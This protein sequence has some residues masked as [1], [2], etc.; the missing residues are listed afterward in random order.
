M[1]EANHP[2]HDPGQ[3][4][5]APWHE[6]DAVAESIQQSNSLNQ[7]QSH[8][9]AWQA[10]E[11]VDFPNAISV[12]AID[13]QALY[14]DDETGDH[15]IPPATSFIPDLPLTQPAMAA[16]SSTESSIGS[17][18]G[19][20]VPPTTA[21]L[22][23]LIQELNQCNGELLHR[24]AQLEEALD[25][26][27]SDLQAEI[28]RAHEGA[29]ASPAGSDELTV[30]QA[31]VTQLLNQLEF[32]SQAK[33]RQQILIETLQG[34]LEN[35]QER[36]AQ[37][38]RECALV[39]GRH[40]EQAHLLMQSD[41]MCRDLQ[42]RLQRQQR[43]TLQFKAA[44]EKCLEVPPPRY[45]DPSEGGQDAV[46]F[47]SSATPDAWDD[48]Q[49]GFAAQHFLPKVQRIQ[50]WS[51]QPDFP[52]DDWALDLGDGHQTPIS[53]A[54]APEAPPAD[55]AEADLD[56][57]H[58]HHSSDVDQAVTSSDADAEPEAAGQFPAMQT[59]A[60]AQAAAEWATEPEAEAEPVS[61]PAIGQPSISYDLR[62]PT[63]DWRSSKELHIPSVAPTSSVSTSAA[64]DLTQQ[65]WQPDEL[66]SSPSDDA[67][68]ETE[69]EVHGDDLRLALHGAMPDDDRAEVTSEEA[70]DAL[71]Q[72]LARLIEVSADD[73]LKANLSQSFGEFEAI[74]FEAEQRSTAAPGA[75]SIESWTAPKQP[76]LAAAEFT[77]AVASPATLAD[78]GGSTESGSSQVATADA[79]DDMVAAGLPSGLT[80]KSNWPSPVVYPLR[81]PKKIDSLAAVDLPSFPR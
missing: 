25:R 39:Q 3:D 40:N 20:S 34:Q 61:R 32:A 31:Q 14:G 37:L 21:E 54:I 2:S 6:P 57:H 58:I 73:V 19:S 29:T 52:A 80:V 33:Q 71:W 17:S 62:K 26:S 78:W 81:Q 53:A 55:Q 36:V 30:T 59:V 47:A 72:D 1:N 7:S 41:N 65:P 38:E 16:D 51:A 11:T 50:P 8:S 45:E 68:A 23:G 79:A 48:P 5:A 60:E 44:L 28:A 74:E 46:S 10:W 49:G 15:P 67:L 24:V 13:R 4:A 76:E 63:A 75:S 22:I 35:S 56:I 69:A 43:Y 77:S 12:D 27:Q 66:A 9:E 42:I 70:E 18:A 64:A